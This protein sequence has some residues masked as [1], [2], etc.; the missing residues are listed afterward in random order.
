M[1]LNISTTVQVPPLSD[2]EVWFASAAA[3]NAYWTS[4][5]LVVNIDG[6]DTSIYTEVLP[7]YTLKSVQMNLQDGT[8]EK[9]VT[10]AQLDTVLVYLNTLNTAF[11]NMRDEMKA[12]GLITNSQ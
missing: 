7:D 5:P 12:G 3:W 11:K 6:A 10:E 1:G 8:T 4:I 2:N 9:F